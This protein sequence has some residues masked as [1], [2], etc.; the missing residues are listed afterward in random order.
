MN[1]YYFLFTLAL[2]LHICS[3]SDPYFNT[4]FSAKCGDVKITY[5]FYT[6]NQQKLHCGYPG[7]EVSCQNGSSPY[8]NISG[9]NY[10][11][12]KI[13][14]ENQTFEVVNSIFLPSAT[15]TPNCSGSIRNM[16]LDS[17][18][19]NFA[20]S[21]NEL[22]L[23]VNCPQNS[24][25]KYKQ[26]MVNCGALAME[27][28]DP[29]FEGLK[30]KCDRVVLVPY[31]GE[32][33]SFTEVLRR[34]VALRWVANNCSDCAHSGGQCGYNQTSSAFQCYCSDGSYSHQC[35]VAAASAIAIVLLVVLVIY[36]R[37]R[38]AAK[39]STFIDLYFPEWIYNQLEVEQGTALQ[40]IMNDEENKIQRKIILVGLWCIQNFPS[41]RPSM[42]KV[43]EMLEGSLESLQMPPKP[44]LSS[45][46][47]S[48]S[49]SSSTPQNV[50]TSI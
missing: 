45:P 32:K 15:Q 24:S 14:Y 22:I 41:N 1:Y 18:L 34:G 30:H 4:C 43:V 49:Y 23:L 31:E 10:V 26:Y 48:V 16:T 27:E 6:A 47:R 3:S 19:F 11:I 42:N 9:S 28:N 46:S 2:I 44:D 7:F 39:K 35:Q 20:A 8:L 21:H 33:E 40:G 37:R 5:P 17:S 36:L 50:V 13:W 25:T 12:K 38:H 29:E